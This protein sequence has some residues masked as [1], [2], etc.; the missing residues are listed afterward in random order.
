[1]SG[2]AIPKLEALLQR[3]QQRRAEPRAAS[4]PTPAR[5]T[6]QRHSHPV[7]LSPFSVPPNTGMSSPPSRVSKLPAPTPLEESMEQVVT[8]HKPEPQAP[9]PPLDVGPPA[10]ELVLDEFDP[11]SNLP[12]PVP[13]AE[14]PRAAPAVTAQPSPATAPVAAKPA[15]VPSAPSARIAPSLPDAAPS[16][17]SIVS[18]PRVSEPKT[19]GELLELALSLRPSD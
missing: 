16:P 2:A 12:T 3:V 19:F 7:S 17:V 13:V 8:V 10:G 4:A 15:V 14:Q 1:M 11:A 9:P 18:A 5:E 6:Q